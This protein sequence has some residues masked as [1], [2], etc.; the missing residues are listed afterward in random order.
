MEVAKKIFELWAENRDKDIS[1]WFETH[2]IDIW[3]VREDGTF[4]NETV[5][6]DSP[7]DEAIDRFNVVKNNTRSL[8]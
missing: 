8:K 3:G 4:I 2:I 6:Y 1:V 5:Y 7:I